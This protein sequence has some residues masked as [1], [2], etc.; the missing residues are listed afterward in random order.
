MVAFGSGHGTD[1]GIERRPVPGEE[2]NL[3]A[4]FVVKDASGQK[5]G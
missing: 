4:A 2:K 1:I 3:A 5:L